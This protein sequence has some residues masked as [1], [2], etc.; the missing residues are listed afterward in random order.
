[1]VRSR[2]VRRS[3]LDIHHRA[4]QARKST[5]IRR[6]RRRSRSQRS[7]IGAGPAPAADRSIET[8]QESAAPRRRC[9]K[10]PDEQAE[11]LRL[12]YFE[13]QPHTMIAQQNGLPP[14]PS[15][16]GFASPWQWARTGG[17]LTDTLHDA[18]MS[19]TR[20]RNCCST[21]PPA[22]PEP[23]SRARYSSGALSEAAMR[24]RGSS[25]SAARCSKRSSRGMA[26]DALDCLM[27]RLDEQVPPS[28]P[29][30]PAVGGA[31]V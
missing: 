18:S 17:K 27:A 23:T 14:V 2:A 31:R 7:G 25:R 16:R 29:R 12:A 28:V 11:L 21:T 4:Q 1:M 9:Q 13:D 22:P 5:A 24:W 6:E 3:H 10:L 30:S 20:L 26:P 15:S 19:I 8:A